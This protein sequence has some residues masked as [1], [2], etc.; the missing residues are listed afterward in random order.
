MLMAVFERSSRQSDKLAWPSVQ[1]YRDRHKAD[2]RPRDIYVAD[3]VIGELVREL[4]LI[5][6]TSA[7]P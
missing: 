6:E 2:S 5:L 3:E 4:S 7:F 1:V